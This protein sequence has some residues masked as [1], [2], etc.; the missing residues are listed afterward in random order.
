MSKP[1]PSTLR[2]RYC[3]PRR[4]PT[5]SLPMS[6]DIDLSMLELG[7]EGQTE[8]EIAA[9]LQSSGSTAEADASAWKASASVELAGE[10]SG[11]LKFASPPR[12]DQH[13][14]VETAFLRAI[15]HQLRQ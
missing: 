5:F 6:A 7:A 8:Q 11:A 1:S 12:V 14:Q 9:T 3:Q 15:G 10:P 2:G 13:V 4:G